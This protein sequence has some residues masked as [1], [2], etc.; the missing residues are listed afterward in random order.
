LIATGSV[1]AIPPIPGLAEA[2]YWTSDEVLEA[3][4]LP[5]SIIVLG[6]GAIAL[7]MAHY[8]NALGVQV[9]ILQ[10]SA[11]LLSMIDPEAGGAVREAFIKRGM[12]VECNT[13]I[14]RVEQ[15]ERKRVVYR[16]DGIVHTV[17][18]DE[19]LVALGRKPAVRNLGLDAAGVTIAGGGIE[20]ADTQETSAPGIY[21][22][23]MSAVRWRSFISRSS[24]GRWPRGMRR[25]CL[26][27][28]EGSNAAW[29]TA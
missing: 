13:T 12:V 14:D 11:T 27:R 19:I 9:T 3:E 10:R 6:G 4:A 5:A 25:D 21:A 16:K 8:L 1:V 2:G 18:A 17:E 22:A 29:T 15:S 20:I 7:E 23:G 28:P 26:A 24:R